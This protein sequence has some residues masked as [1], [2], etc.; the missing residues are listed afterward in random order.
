MFNVAKFKVLYS[1]FA[2]IDDAEISIIAEDVFCYVGNCK[3]ECKEKLWMLATAHS[4]FLS[5]ERE[6]GNAPSGAITSASIGGV[7]IGFTQPRANDDMGH[8]FTLSP[9]GLQYLALL[10]KCKVRVKYIGG[11]KWGGRYR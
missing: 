3:P 5:K 1:A 9:Y 10:E 11:S 4:L 7:S 6:K 8:W 2:D